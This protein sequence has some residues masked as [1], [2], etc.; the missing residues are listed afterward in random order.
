MTAQRK[1]T[2]LLLTIV[3]VLLCTVQALAGIDQQ[4]RITATDPVAGEQLAI[5]QQL[6]LRISYESEIPLRFQ[7]S[8]Y[9]KGEK[10]AFGFYSNKPELNPAGRDDALGWVGFSNVTVIDEIRVQIQDTDGKLVGEISQPLPF[11]WQTA[12]GE[13]IPDKAAWVT[14]MERHQAWQRENLFDPLEQKKKTLT[15]MLFYLNSAAVPLYLLFQIYALMKFRGR[16]RDLA[17]IPLVSLL[18]MVLAALSSFGMPLRY[19]VILLFRGVPFVLLYLL[20]VWYVRRRSLSKASE[21]K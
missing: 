1:P 8:A 13:A 10:L 20:V 11:T 9:R 17:I 19:W 12:T 7:L 6:F 14:K 16:W 4:V 5:D 3:L 2:L 18:P 15:E 21:S